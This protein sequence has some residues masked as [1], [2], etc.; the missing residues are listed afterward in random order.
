[1]EDFNKKKVLLVQPSSDLA[2]VSQYILK[3]VRHGSGRFAFYF[4]G[5]AGGALLAEDD[6]KKNVEF[7]PLSENYQI[8]KGFAG[9]IKAL[10]EIIIGKGIDIVHA[11]TLRAAFLCACALRKKHLVKFIYTPHGFRFI[12]KKN[13]VS[14]AIFFLID[15]FVCARADQVVVLSQSEKNDAIYNHLPKAVSYAIIPTFIDIVKPA[16]DSNI[17]MG[18]SK[19]EKSFIVSMIGRITSQKNPFGFLE[20]AQNI[21][22]VMPSA[23]FVWVGD[24]ELRN[25]FESRIKMS[26]ME[27]F[28]FITGQVSHEKVL[29]VPSY[30]N[31]ILFTS[32]YEGLPIVLLEMLS[33][34]VPIVA[35]QVGS[36]SDIIKQGETGWLFQPNNYALAAEL[37]LNISKMAD[38][39][40]EHMKIVQRHLIAEKYSPEFRE[41][42]EYEKIYQ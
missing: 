25:E 12:Q 24:G 4:A 37:I 31:A 10:Q 35:A 9:Q 21:K 41:A 40:I 3:I 20:I 14:R 13:V 42:M 2:G 36:V 27:E 39:D 33:I 15:Y 1:M 32:W 16:S 29:S 23:L 8:F 7:S 11:H 28:F 26:G 34:G 22:K 5:P 38:S 17:P 30:T 18:I 19:K 6:F